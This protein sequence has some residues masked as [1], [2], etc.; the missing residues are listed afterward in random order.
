MGLSGMGGKHPVDLG[1]VSFS[2]V[3]GRCTIV[4]LGGSVSLEARVVISSIIHRVSDFIGGS[5]IGGGRIENIIFLKGAFAGGRFLRSVHSYCVLSSGGC[6][7]CERAR[8]P[9]VVN[10][11]SIVSYS[12]FS[13]RAGTIVTGNR[14]R[15]IHGRETGRRGSHVSRTGHEGRRRRRGSGRTQRTRFECGRTVRGITIFR[16]GRGCTRVLS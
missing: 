4:I 5:G 16:G 13:T 9:G 3:A 10:I 15:L 1:G 7:F 8:L 12:R 11:C 6:L 2:K 14:L